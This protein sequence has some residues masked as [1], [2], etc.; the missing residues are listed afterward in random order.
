VIPESD[1]AFWRFSLRFYRRPEV[2]PLCLKLQDEHDVDVNC[3]FFV[4]FLAVNR[5]AVTVEDVR[6][7]DDAIAA[8]RQLVVQPLRRLRQAMKSGVAPVAVLASGPLR[9]AIKRDE[10][11]SEQLQQL[12]MEHAFAVESTGVQMAPRE[13]AK[14]NL[15]AYGDFV[16]GLPIA[17]IS[18]LINSLGAEFLL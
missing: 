15:A 13:A 4:L 9:D 14:A 17:A 3:L 11:Q 16:G 5:R 1:S 12:A 7:I 6:R 10:L 8:W 18:S 2:P